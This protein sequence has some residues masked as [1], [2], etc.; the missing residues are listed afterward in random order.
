MSTQQVGVDRNNMGFLTEE[1]WNIYLRSTKSTLL[2][3]MYFSHMKILP[4]DVIQ[5]KRLILSGH[6]GGSVGYVSVRLLIS[7]QVMISR[8]VGS[9]PA[10]S[11]P[12]TVQSLLGIFPPS[13]SGPPVPS[14]SLSLKMN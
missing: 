8:F 5:A 4:Q 10:S 2:H 11:S 6:L 3:N 9:S 1:I 7:A 14:F 12:L 13:P